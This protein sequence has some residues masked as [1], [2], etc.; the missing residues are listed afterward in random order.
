MYYRKA[1]ASER[2]PRPLIGQNLGAANR[3][4]RSSHALA[5]ELNTR[6]RERRGLCVK[7]QACEHFA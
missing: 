4:A 6:G 1:L 2:A 3:D 5:G 7:R